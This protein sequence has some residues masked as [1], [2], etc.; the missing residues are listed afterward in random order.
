MSSFEWHEMKDS[1]PSLGSGN[2]VVL[3]TRGGLYVASDYSRYSQSGRGTYFYIP[4]RRDNFMD[5][6]SVKAWAEIPP[7][8]V[9]E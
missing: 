8:E 2:Y 5:S 3:G 1:E 6:S 7:L 4:N 9:G